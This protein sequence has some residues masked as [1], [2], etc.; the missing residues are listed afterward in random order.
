MKLC[1]YPDNWGPTIEHML[2]N[3]DGFNASD[4][5]KA[6]AVAESVGDKKFA[7]LLLKL[8]ADRGAEH[9]VVWGH[10]G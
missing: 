8:A 9:L 2:R 7:E 10:L 3:W 5:E 6:S 1:D 4:Y